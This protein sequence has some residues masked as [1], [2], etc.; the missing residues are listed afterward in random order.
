MIPTRVERRVTPEHLYLH[1]PFCLRRCSYCDFAVT[2]TRQPPIDAWLDAVAAEL[3]LRQ[4]I[5]GWSRL[6]LR[7]IYIGGG[8]PSLLG[9]GTM[10]RLRDVL[11]R[12]ADWDGSVEWTAE[13]N[14]ETFT[15][16]LAGDWARA[17]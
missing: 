4:R 6:A 1:V 16:G 8:T 12:F 15:A 14:P 10:E 2:A 7:T 17:G 13:A 3:E 9:E 11:A 5:G